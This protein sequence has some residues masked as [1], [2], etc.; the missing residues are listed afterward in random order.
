VGKYD[1]LRQCP[2]VPLQAPLS[3]AVP[4]L[5]T[6]AVERLIQGDYEKAPVAGGS[7]ETGR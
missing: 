5:V 4:G 7:P 1:E 3:E 2:L 6:E